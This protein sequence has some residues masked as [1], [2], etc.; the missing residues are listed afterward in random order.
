M[1]YYLT[2][3]V[4]SING[5]SNVCN[6]S[7]GLF[8]DASAR[9]LFQH[10]RNQR[11]NRSTFQLGTPILSLVTRSNTLQQR[12]TYHTFLGIFHR[13]ALYLRG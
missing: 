12:Y 11:R 7:L 1:A 5:I 13:Y 8:R 3:C 9:F 6:R 2:E 10:I 4:T